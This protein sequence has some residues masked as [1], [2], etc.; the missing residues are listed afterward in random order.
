MHGCPASE[1]RQSLGIVLACVESN[2]QRLRALNCAANPG[3][4][5][6]H[7]MPEKDLAEIIQMPRVFL[8]SLGIGISVTD[9]EEGR[10][11]FANAEYCR[12]VGYTFDQ[13]RTDRICFLELT[14]PDD[15]ERNRLQHARLLAGEIDLYQIDERYL[16]KD[17]SLVWA[18]V[19]AS[20]IRDVDGSI[21]W[22]CAVVEDI[23]EKKILEGQLAAAEKLAGLETFNLVVEAEGRSPGASMSSSPSLADMMRH[24]H[25]D[26]RDA[27]EKVLRRAIVKRTG[28]T[29]EYRIVADSGAIRW[30]RAIGTC[31]YSPSEACT[32]LVGSTIDI[33]E[34]R[35]GGEANTP[36]PIRKILDH[37]EKHWNQK[38]S[39]E[40]LAAQYGISPRAVYQYFSAH[41]ASLGEKIK[42]NR[43]QHARRMLCNPDPGETVTSIALKCGF[44]NPGHFAKE[45]RKMFGE[46]PSET[47]RPLPPLQ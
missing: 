6:S 7:S 47:L 28:Y 22:Y 5:P 14:H 17:G 3:A 12:I 32:H 9:V 26:D 19:T 8:D 33:T 43:M 35:A 37:I 27:L 21:R 23:T 10:I 24:V 36:E 11:R 38:I 2:F 29:Q 18:R 42:Q 13:L 25:P 30:V 34:T 20:P 45:Y 31:V 40:Q 4:P 1:I 15:R 46:T 16:R 41:G 44:N 39:I